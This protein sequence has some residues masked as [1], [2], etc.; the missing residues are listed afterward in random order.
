VFVRIYGAAPSG[1]EAVRTF[2][3]RSGVR[4]VV[5]NGKRVYRV[6]PDVLGDGL[7]LGAPPGTDF[8]SHFA[9]APNPRTVGLRKQPALLSPDHQLRFD[10]YAMRVRPE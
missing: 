1:V 2:L 9:L 5:F 6:V 10:F 8:P 7:I 3:Y 4:F